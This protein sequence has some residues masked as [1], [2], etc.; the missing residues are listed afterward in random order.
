MKRTAAYCLLASWLVL[1]GYAAYVLA[2][3]WDDVEGGDLV[4]VLMFWILPCVAGV[5][6]VLANG[7]HRIAPADPVSE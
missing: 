4:L 3:Q 6:V 7:L 5:Y 1:L 2:T